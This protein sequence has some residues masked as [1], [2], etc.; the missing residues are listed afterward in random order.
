MFSHFP[1]EH[2][3][4]KIFT[5]DSLEFDG[6]PALQWEEDYYLITGGFIYFFS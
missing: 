4:F 2:K 6:Y 1:F 3:K 5:W